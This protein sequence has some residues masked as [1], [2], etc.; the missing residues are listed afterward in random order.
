MGF[1]WRKYDENDAH[2]LLISWYA[3]NKTGKKILRIPIHG[4]EPYTF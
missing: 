1:L 2:M 4:F 3:N